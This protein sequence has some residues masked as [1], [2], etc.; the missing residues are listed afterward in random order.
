FVINGNRILELKF[1]RLGHTVIV[2]P[3]NV[4]FNRIAKARSKHLFTAIQIPTAMPITS[5]I[6]C[7][8]IGT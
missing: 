4:E 2:F 6:S 3:T 8:R 1:L 7:D 5:Y